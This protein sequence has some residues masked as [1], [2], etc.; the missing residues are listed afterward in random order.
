MKPQNNACR[1]VQIVVEA[2]PLDSEC[3]QTLHRL[4]KKSPSE[5][6]LLL[7]GATGKEASMPRNLR[8]AGVGHRGHL[9]RARQ[10]M[11]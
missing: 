1:R 2:Q 7:Q 9:E 11:W 8:L 3:V 5:N 6:E 10:E 4:V